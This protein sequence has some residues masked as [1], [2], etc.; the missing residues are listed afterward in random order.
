ADVGGDCGPRVQASTVAQ[1]GNGHGP[2]LHPEGTK[3]HKRILVLL[4]GLSALVITPTAVSLATGSTK[5]SPAAVLDAELGLFT[6][7]D[8]EPGN[9]RLPELTID[10]S[11]YPDARGVQ[12]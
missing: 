9:G 2:T 7:T 12:F 8:V 10:D 5:S 11:V 1:S 3:L 6:W 4:A